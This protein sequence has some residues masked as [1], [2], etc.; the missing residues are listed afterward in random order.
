MACASPRRRSTSTEGTPADGW[1]CPAA[2]EPEAAY[3]VSLYSDAATNGLAVTFT[4]AGMEHALSC[5]GAGEL[6]EMTAALFARFP[7]EARAEERIDWAIPKMTGEIRG[8][9]LIYRAAI[10]N[11][12]RER[13][14]P[15]NIVF[16]EYR[17]EFP[18][19]TAGLSARAQHL[20]YA[21]LC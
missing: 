5:E 6:A 9:A 20:Y 11:S 21:S 7:H 4:D 15:V 3:I 14:N 12:T 19:G 8:H 1:L 2:E 16:P 18:D 10:R 13:A 17:G